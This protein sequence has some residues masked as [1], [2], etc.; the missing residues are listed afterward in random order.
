[1]AVRQPRYSKEEFARRGNEL[2]E[3][4]IRAQVE[5]GNHGKIAGRNTGHAIT[6]AVASHHP[7]ARHPNHASATN[8]ANP[9]IGPSHRLA[10][11][12]ACSRLKPVNTSTTR[13][14]VTPRL[15][16][17]DVHSLGRPHGALSSVIQ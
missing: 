15:V 11:R 14:A 6:Q 9:I 10:T 17:G 5:T 8:D 1:M 13:T 3:R 7:P 4:Q 16:M 12:K 2:Y